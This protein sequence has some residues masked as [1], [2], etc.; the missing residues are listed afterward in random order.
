MEKIVVE[1]GSTC[2]KIDKFDGSN[3]IHLN[4]VPID[5]KRHFKIENKLY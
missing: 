3:V 1:V 5:F 4:T 2:T